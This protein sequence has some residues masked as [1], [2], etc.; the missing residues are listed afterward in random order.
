MSTLDGIIVENFDIDS[1]GASPGNLPAVEIVTPGAKIERVRDAMG[2]SLRGLDDA[3]GYKQ[4]RTYSHIRKG[5]NAEPTREYLSRLSALAGQRL[6]VAPSHEWYF[7]GRDTEPGMATATS[8]MTLPLRGLL[9]GKSS[10]LDAI[11]DRVAFRASFAVP[12]GSGYFQ[13]ADDALAPLRRGSLVLMVPTDTVA[14]EALAIVEHEGVLDIAIT[15]RVPGG[16]KYRPLSPLQSIHED[17]RQVGLI[18][19]LVRA[20]DHGPRVAL[21]YIFGLTLAMITTELPNLTKST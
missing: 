15:E 1:A 2:L 12:E 13:L 4:G 20:S 11:V 18:V 3:L 5:R 19:E 14:H 9:P 7:D 8:G 16:A 21:E 10:D 17:A 6:G